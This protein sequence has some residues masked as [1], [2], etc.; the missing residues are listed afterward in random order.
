MP[1]RPEITLAKIRTRGDGYLPGLIG[2]RFTG[3]AENRIESELDIRSELLAPNGYLHAASI[4]ALADTTCG[5]GCIAHL[6][7]GA[8]NFT[9]IELKSNF[10]GTARE[11]TLACV[12]TPVHLGNTTQVWDAVVS[13]TERERK[14][15]LFRCTQLILWPGAARGA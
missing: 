9:T 11:G 15:A 2:I 3:V 14:L 1:L 13:H 12:A 5:Y 4:I 8:E 10:L 7:S 6:P